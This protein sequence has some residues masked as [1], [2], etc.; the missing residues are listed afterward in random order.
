MLDIEAHFVDLWD[1]IKLRGLSKS[2]AK[3]RKFLFLNYK[4]HEVY[5]QKILSAHDEYK[6]PHKKKSKG[7]AESPWFCTPLWPCTKTA[8]N[9]QNWP[10]FNWS[11]R[12][13]GMSVFDVRHGVGKEIV[14]T[15]WFWIDNSATRY[16]HTCGTQKAHQEILE[17][18]Y[19]NA[20]PGVCLMCAYNV[21]DVCK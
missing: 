4:Y 7:G 2:V 8:Q 11:H 19:Q 17:N 1:F 5:S 13:L 12:A 15:F 6:C 20:V 16:V 3:Y 9:D 14:H 21:P 10:D 18:S